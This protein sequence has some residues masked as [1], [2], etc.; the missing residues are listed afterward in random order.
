MSADIHHAQRQALAFAC[1]RLSLFVKTLN[2][3][4]QHLDEQTKVIREDRF[5]ILV[6]G[7]FKRGK[8]TLINALLQE[9][10]LPHQATPATPLPIRL[11]YGEK[12]TLFL[13]NQQGELEEQ[14][15]SSLSQLRLKSDDLGQDRFGLWEEALV[16]LPNA[17]LLQGIEII[18]SPGLHEDALRTARSEAALLKADAIIMVL[19]ATQLLSSAEQAFLEKLQAFGNE[20]LFFVINR[21]DVFLQ[22]IPMPQQ[23]EQQA[24]LTARLSHAWQRLWPKQQPRIFYLS[25]LQA[26]KAAQRGQEDSDFAI[27]LLHLKNF[28]Q[29]DRIRQRKQRL[30]GFFQE[31][32]RTLQRYWQKLDQLTQLNLH[33]ALQQEEMLRRQI[34]RLEEQQQSLTIWLN[35][36]QIEW[37]KWLGQE[38]NYLENQWLKLIQQTIETA[39]SEK[40]FTAKELS[41]KPLFELL[42][43]GEQ[44]L[45]TAAETW[46]QERLQPQLELTRQD[47]KNYLA[48]EIALYKQ[49]FTWDDEVENQ[50][51]P[52]QT[53]PENYALSLNVDSLAARHFLYGLPLVSGAGIWLIGLSSFSLPLALVLALFGFVVER[54]L[55]WQKIQKELS[56]YLKPVL[57]NI[58]ESFIH[59]HE[60]YVLEKLKRWQLPFSELL[61][62]IHNTT[63]RLRQLLKTTQAQRQN[64]QQQN[65]A[66]FKKKQREESEAKELFQAIYDL[67]NQWQQVNVSKKTLFNGEIIEALGQQLPGLLPQLPANLYV[68]AQV[69]MQQIADWQNEKAPALWCC[70][71]AGS[72]KSSIVQFLLGQAFLPPPALAN[73]AGLL[74]F[75]PG[76]TWQLYVFYQEK[77]SH[78]QTI[79]PD[80]AL[81]VLL[82]E[83]A[84]NHDSACYRYQFTVPGLTYQLYDCPAFFNAQHPLWPYFQ[85]HSWRAR[86]IYSLDRL[87]LGQFSEFYQ[88]VY[89]ENNLSAWFFWSSTALSANHQETLKKHLADR[90]HPQ[91]IQ[92]LSPNLALLKQILNAKSYLPWQALWS[93][94]TLMQFLLPGWQAKHLDFFWRF[95]L[96]WRLQKVACAEV[97]E[98]WRGKV[99][100]FQQEDQQ[101]L[102]NR[103]LLL[104]ANLAPLLDSGLGQ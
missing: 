67:L 7:E 44:V 88:Q 17:F 70:G 41:E 35:K 52:R 71:S 12:R 68:R 93:E 47:L 80:H 61:Q 96:Q 101:Q 49:T 21:Y 11:G 58:T 64:N 42:P 31:E 97:L 99:A 30:L 86:I 50:D 1:E 81:A 66:A 25:A 18:D 8:S 23:A 40:T 32:Q 87:E 62:E 38:K 9:D 22:S 48:K 69:L 16:T 4:V 78:Q 29:Q 39:L 15:F 77:L 14:A 54:Q 94:N 63:A 100:D 3:P 74:H 82:A 37:R 90:F 59:D 5:R 34:K 51:L 28:L 33:E 27:F 10:L 102:E 103:S 98:A 73:F 83:F 45:K 43:H 60:I 6:L 20:N 13:K 24:Q 26:L 75:S 55:R 104:A 92:M 95:W 2:L 76:E 72:S 79:S 89:K 84:K 85:K 46:Q 19:D 65:Q 53:A 91:C 56:S 57:A 36:Q